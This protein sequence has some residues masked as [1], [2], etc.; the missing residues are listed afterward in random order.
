MTLAVARARQVDRSPDRRRA[1]QRVNS[2]RYRERRKEC[3]SVVLVEVDASRLD[4]LISVGALSEWDDR[5]R[6]KIGQAIGDVLDSIITDDGA[7]R[8]IVRQ[9][10]P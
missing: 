7:R 6:D 5:D 9:S 3:A 8:A 2:A 1:R 10:R 4:T